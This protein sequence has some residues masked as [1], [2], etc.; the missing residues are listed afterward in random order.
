MSKS[1]EFIYFQNFFPPKPLK[2][3]LS[4]AKWSRWWRNRLIWDDEGV[5][6]IAHTRT[7]CSGGKETNRQ[8]DKQTKS[9]DMNGITKQNLMHPSLKML[10]ISL[11][12]LNVFSCRVLFRRKQF[13]NSFAFYKAE[14]RAKALN[15]TRSFFSSKT[16]IKTNLRRH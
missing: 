3:K 2:Y 4:T 16:E 15:K 7:S 1:L 12:I 6:T 10:P 8:T 5:L 14:I 11:N 13:K 9:T